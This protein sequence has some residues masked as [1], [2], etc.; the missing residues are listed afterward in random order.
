MQ[1]LGPSG[2]AGQ[3]VS[4]VAQSPGPWHRRIGHMLPDAG[5]VHVAPD[6]AWQHSWDAQ[7]SGPSQARITPD[8]HAPPCGMHESMPTGLPGWSQQT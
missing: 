6:P 2:A 7:S 1:T 4:S 8:G 3:Q 5:S